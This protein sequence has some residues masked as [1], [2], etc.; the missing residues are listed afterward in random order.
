MLEERAACTPISIWA[1]SIVSALSEGL[2]SITKPKPQHKQ[3]NSTT[4]SKRQNKLLQHK[5]ANKTKRAKKPNKPS[6]AKKREEG[7]KG[8]RA[9]GRKQATDIARTR[10][11]PRCAGGGWAGAL[12]DAVPISC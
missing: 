3:R 8:E 7:D 11:P 2:L 1:G 10:T 5:E 4:Q 9:G 12:P 6:Q